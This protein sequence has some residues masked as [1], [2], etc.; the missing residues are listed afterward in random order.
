MILIPLYLHD[1]LENWFLSVYV[2]ISVVGELSPKFIWIADNFIT[3][4]EKRK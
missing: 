4:Y 2:H 1:R 3:P